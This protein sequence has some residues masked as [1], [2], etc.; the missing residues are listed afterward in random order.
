M[1]NF[2]KSCHRGFR[3]I[4]KNKYRFISIILLIT[5]SSQL[6]WIY[7]CKNDTVTNPSITPT[8]TSTV[9][10]T[11]NTNEIGGNGLQVQ[12]A[13][14][15]NCAVN[16]GSYSTDVSKIGTQLLFI[17][18]NNSKIRGFTLSRILSGQ[19]A[20]LTGD[21]ISTAYSVMFLT[22]G[23]ATTQPDSTISK[24][25]RLNQLNT[26]QI[27]VT[28]FRSNLQS[29]ALS[30][31]LTQQQ[32]VNLISNCI[33]EF[34]GIDTISNNTKKDLMQNPDAYFQVNKLNNGTVDLK[35]YNW[36]WVNVFRRDLKSDGGEKG[37]SN[38]Q[39]PMG[40]GV[41]YSWG[42]IFQQ[43]CLNPT[44]HND[45]Y[46][47]SI[48]S[49]VYKSEYWV[50]GLGFKQPTEIPPQSI[51]SDI[52]NVT[53][54][55]ILA[56]EFFPVCDIITGGTFSNITDI[57]QK[58]AN[59]A[60]QLLTHSDVNDAVNALI[61]SGDFA[62]AQR[63]LI[64]ALMKFL[65]Y[66]L[67]SSGIL[68]SMGFLTASAA[69]ILSGLIVT[70]GISIIAANSIIFLS[71]IFFD[72]PKFSKYEIF[73]RIP[74]LL[75]PPNNSSNQSLTPTLSWDVAV[76]ATNYHV[77]V[78]DNQNFNNPKV[79]QNIPGSPPSYTIPTGILSSNT[80]YFWRV[81]STGSEG[82][83]PWSS[84]WNFTTL[85]GGGGLSAPNLLSPSNGATNQSLTPLLDWGDVT[86]A[87]SYTAQV[88]TN[89]NFS[90]TVVNQSGLTSSQY[91]I[92]GGLS[93]N[94]LY[95][96]RANATNTSSTSPWSSVWSFTT[97][98]G[99]GGLSAPNLLSPANGATN[100]PLTPA[101]DWSD[102]TGATSYTVQVSTNSN[103]STTVV[104][105]SGLTTSQYAVPSGLSNNTLYYWRA[106]ATNGSTTS[107][108]SS[109]WNFTT[110]TS[111]GSG[112]WAPLGSG[113][114]SQVRALTVYNN[115]VIAGGDFTIAG[116]NSASYIAMWNG[117]SWLT[118]GSG[119]GGG[120]T[121]V[122]ALAVYNNELI[123][124][125]WFTTA[126]GISANFIAKWNGS[127]WAPLGS[128]MSGSS[129]FVNALIV[130]NGGLVAGGNFTTAGGVSANFIAKWNGSSWAP[131]GT[132]LNN[133][134]D[135]LTV[136][137]G[138]LIVGGAFTTAGGNS[139][140][141]IALWNGN[142]WS[143]L[144][145]GMN[146]SV[147]SLNI[148][149]SDLIAGGYFTNAGGVSANYIAKWDGNLWTPLGSGMTGGVNA[150]NIYN[151]ELIAGGIFTSAG[152]NS[153]SYIAQWNGNS[154]STLSSGMSNGG[155]VWALTVYG[156]NL[157]AGGSFTT[158][159]GNSANYIAQWH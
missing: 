67:S 16:N 118:L 60:T 37:V 82:T 71:L 55:S 81:T 13:Y 102:V 101:L 57:M 148:Y 137:N 10:G 92:P 5:F 66:L 17:T 96:W 129:S 35:N 2:I 113:M 139:A 32:T 9:N 110:L 74:Q 7:G 112:Q 24:L 46:Y 95:Y 141:R 22:P 85:I 21:A 106:N 157:I 11:I 138:A 12:S 76:T 136:Y 103:F 56:Y 123:A 6:Y 159:G 87:T 52:N 147:N 69:A 100:Q 132:G 115:A 121:R 131:L 86:G 83:S 122:Y 140:N 45:N 124:G 33:F 99:G 36:R 114:N 48:S 51:N 88:S 20:L 116:G 149:G 30:D 134:V 146:S 49:D 126:G 31:L 107:P 104:N 63:T 94:T 93:N 26:F 153:A 8:P 34:S 77:Q 40:G 72:T 38:I 50:N 3:K 23:I 130:Y 73:S 15:I 39:I 29:N 89:S 42:C 62:G 144:G 18:D 65:P 90:T 158:A 61:A 25:N 78:A 111:G 80:Q 79:D 98:T 97:L 128:G 91:T 127:S 1:K 75:F 47:G 152:G 58:T 117:S 44:V 143:P 119:M 142:S 14:K 109:V 43:S 108:W 28:Y 68:V 105:Q 59:I 135:A 54:A 70:I 120:I 53:A 151:S 155:I 125:G 154:W 150:L 19:P 27:L 4:F 156:N 133:G 145:S 84:V 64:N 41:S